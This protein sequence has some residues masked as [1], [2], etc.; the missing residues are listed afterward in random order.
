MT[1][2]TLSDQIQDALADKVAQLDPADFTDV[3][4]EGGWLPH[5]YPQITTAP[6]PYTTNAEARPDPYMT[7]T[8][9]GWLFIEVGN[10]R[11]AIPDREEWDKLINMGERMWNSYEVS[12]PPPPPGERWDYED[13]KWTE[14][15]HT[16]TTEDQPPPPPPGV[17]DEGDDHAHDPAD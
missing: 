11:I 8:A 3:V 15:E 13:G 9:T 6:I 17:A 10:T 12:L 14:S 1:D 4:P 2:E 7:I 16:A 5:H